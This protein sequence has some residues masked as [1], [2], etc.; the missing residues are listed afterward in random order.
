MEPT[1]YDKL[2][3]LEDRMWWFAAL[4]RNL[5]MLTGRLPLE[6][7]SSPMLDAGCGTGGFLVRLGEKYRDRPV[8]GLDLN[9][10]ACSR[11]AVKSR[12]PVCAGSANDLPFADGCIAV[13][14]T[15]DLL[16]HQAV[17]EVRALRQFHRC[18]AEGGCL[19][20]NLPA[21]TWL[22]SRHDAA[23]HNVRRYTASGLR[24][25]LHATGFDLVFISYWNAVLF[26]WM[27]FIRKLFRG[28]PDAGS[29]VRSYPTAVDA[30]CRAV[31]AF[32][33]ALLSRGLRFPFGGSVVAIAAKR[34]VSNE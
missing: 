31:T 13:I 11:A 15:A 20:V 10:R 9:F 18:L 21:Y 5:L 22:L 3:S 23:V 32:E 27:A 6:A 24:G 4:H 16:C 12:L 14:F 34:G 29:D 17:D 19:I 8:F 2:D 30:L 7:T 1:E 33:T 28:N 25:L 26:P